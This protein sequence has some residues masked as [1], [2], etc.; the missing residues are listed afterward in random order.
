MKWEIA[1]A[2]ILLRL[3]LPTARIGGIAAVECLIN[4]GDTR[5]FRLLATAKS[6]ELHI[7]LGCTCTIGYLLIL[8]IF[9]VRVPLATY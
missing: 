5:H 4:R 6:E 7:T 3:H 8:L 2:R 9:P 1:G